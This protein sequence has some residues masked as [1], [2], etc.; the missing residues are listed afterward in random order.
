M[1]NM[2][3]DEV[4][5]SLKNKIER[6]F[7]STFTTNGLGGVLTCGTTGVK[8]GLS[9]SPVSE[10]CTMARLPGLVGLHCTAS[11]PCLC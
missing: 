3:R 11:A 2:C 1:T 4:T 6:I 8:A 10:V 9:H 5:N 7:G